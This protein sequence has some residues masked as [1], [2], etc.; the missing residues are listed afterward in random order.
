ML[1]YKTASHEY[2]WAAKIV[3]KVL[4]DLQSTLTDPRLL[5]GPDPSSSASDN[6]GPSADVIEARL[7][8]RGLLAFDGEERRWPALVAVDVTFG[9]KTLLD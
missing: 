7:G 9:G 5:V 3:D 2:Q 6:S 8:R 1:A 4:A